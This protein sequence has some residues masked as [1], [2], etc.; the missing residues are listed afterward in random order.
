MF[1]ISCNKKTNTV[2]SSNEQEVL[3][4]EIVIHSVFD[5]ERKFSKKFTFNIWLNE[6]TIWREGFRVTGGQALEELIEAYNN[7]K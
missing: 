2:I 4:K 5:S 6:F 1:V 7:I 3:D